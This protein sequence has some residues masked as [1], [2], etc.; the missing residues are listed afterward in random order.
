MQTTFITSITAIALNTFRESVR[1]KILYSVLLFAILLVAIS[2]LF[3]SVTLGDKVRV[4]K[5]FGLFSV[6]FFGAIIT[7]INGVTL[8]N[9]ELKQKTVF[10]ILSKPVSR[11]EFVCGKYFGLV[12]TGLTLVTLMGVSVM[13]FVA[14]LEGK[15]D[16]LLLQAI[17]FTY[18]EVFII[19]STVMFFSSIVVTTTLTGL[20]TFATYIAGKSISYLSYFLKESNESYNQTLAV[21][22]KIFDTVLPDLSSLNIINS[23]VYG[24]STTLTH[25]INATTYSLLYSTTLLILSIL[26]F[27]KR[28]LI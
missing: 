21:I 19:A 9:K 14:F 3:G 18:L 13:I 7:M 2:A 6:S 28:D 24:Q 8:L 20:F 10:N 11:T 17:F 23:I 22:I 1:N 5:D 25:A 4:V 27:R 16:F 12:L 26:I 15:V